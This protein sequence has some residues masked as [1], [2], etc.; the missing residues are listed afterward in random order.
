MSEFPVIT[1]LTVAPLLGGLI[2]AGLDRE[3]IRLARGLA[4]LFSLVAWA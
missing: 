1:L 3:R 4:M 2:V